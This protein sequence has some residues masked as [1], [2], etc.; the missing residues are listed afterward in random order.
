M[1]T[2]CSRTGIQRHMR[3]AGPAGLLWAAL[4]VQGAQAGTLYDFEGFADN[5]SLVNQLPGITFSDATVF[6]A[7]ISLNDIDYPPHSGDNVVASGTTGG[8]TG[9]L[10]VS[11]LM[12]L[13]SLAA[14]FTF[15]DPLTIQA[16]DSGNNPLGSVVSA[17]SSVLG[18][19]EEI[20]VNFSGIASVVITGSSQFTMDDLT[21]ITAQVPEPSTLLLFAVAGVGAGSLGS[22][23][24]REAT[25]KLDSE[26]LASE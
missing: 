2:S 3:W 1:K 17:A 14:F 13:S 6:T 5:T 21:T 16:F 8:G 9:T 26:L 15:S 25:S 4:A 24:P 23:R 22:R 20:S 12:P 10:S 18:S 11:F 19:W 7:G